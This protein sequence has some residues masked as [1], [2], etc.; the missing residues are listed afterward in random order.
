[1]QKE[2]IWFIFYKKISG[3]KSVPYA[4]AVEEA[5][6]FGW[7]DGK[8]KRINDDYYIQW[9]TPRRAKS[10]WS[11]LNIARVEKMIKEGKMHRSGMEEYNKAV[12]AGSPLKESKDKVFQVPEDLMAALE[13]N[14]EARSNFMNF[15]PSACRTYSLW[16]NSAKKAE[17]RVSRIEKIV[18]LAEKN[19]KSAM[20]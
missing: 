17:T 1:M 9:F 3:K 14:P 12:P 19:I 2:G 16:I 11:A 10:K 5:L 7:I 13:K 18:N 6:C 8:L 4:E 15:P 20:L